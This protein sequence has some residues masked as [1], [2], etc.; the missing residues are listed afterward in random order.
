MNGFE[1]ARGKGHVMRRLFADVQTDP[2][3]MVDGDGTYDPAEVPLLVKHL[4]DGWRDMMAGALTGI[5]G[6]IGRRGHPFGNQMF[7]R[8]YRSCSGLSFL[9]PSLASGCFRRDRLRASPQCHRVPKSR[10]NLP[11]THPNHDS[12]WPRCW[13]TIGPARRALSARLG[14]PVVATVEEVGASA[15]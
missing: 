3:V 2:Y 11:C 14:L 6:Q 7:N 9:T 13:S 4:F 10:R 1:P 8:L 12:L 5:A 15:G